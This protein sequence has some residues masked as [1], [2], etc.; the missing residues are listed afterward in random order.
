MFLS[1]IALCGAWHRELY[2]FIP[3]P[4]VIV[5]FDVTL[6]ILIKTCSNFVC[7]YDLLWKVHNIILLRSSQVPCFIHF[8]IVFLFNFINWVVDTNIEPKTDTPAR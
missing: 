4:V 1:K 5:D 7:F 6:H 8:V 3:E 2:I